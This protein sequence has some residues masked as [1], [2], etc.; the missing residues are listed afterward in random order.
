MRMKSA[1]GALLFISALHPQMALAQASHDP[2]AAADY[3]T[4]FNRDKVHELYINVS[5][6]N[7]NAMQADMTDILGAPGSSSSGG[8]GGFP[9]GAAGGGGFPGGGAGGGGGGAGG[10]GGGFPGGGAGGAGGP[11]GGGGDLSILSRD[12]IWV[13]VSF[14][15]EGETWSNVAMRYKGNSSLSSL[16][17]EGNRKLPFKLN[18]DKY[19]SDDVPEQ[20]FFGFN[21][22]GFAPNYGDDSQI[23][24]AYVADLLRDEGIPAAR[25]AFVRVFVDVGSGPQYWGLYTMLEEVDDGA[26]LKREFGSKKGNLYKPDGTGADWTVFNKDGFVKENNEEKADWSDV[27]AAVG[28]LLEEGPGQAA[29]R[30]KLEKTFYVQGFLKWLAVNT[31]IVNWDS[32]GQM[33]HNYYLYANPANEGRLTWIPWDHNLA[34]Q[35]R[36]NS[37][38]SDLFYSSAGTRWPLISRLLADSV[39]KADYTRYLSESLNGLL[40]K[41]AGEAYMQKLH[42]LIAPSVAEE[43][44]GSTTVKS[45]AA[46]ESSL[47]GTSGL[48]QFLDNR[49][50]VA[51]KALGL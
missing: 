17:R 29:W 42:D 11:G 30:E 31:L 38:A 47:T 1:V 26:L 15:Y 23:K 6:E 21:K 37:S 25:W 18:V 14:T 4:V 33:A 39:Y 51:A 40:A 8:G 35:N 44:T 34:L 7:Y 24:E 3:E 5:A 13:N 2:D 16:W 50:A 32:Y 10:G 20:K 19:A 49:R 28:S 12:P 27:E 36:G 41:E 45:Q 9:G 46:F 43:E 48:F 22:L